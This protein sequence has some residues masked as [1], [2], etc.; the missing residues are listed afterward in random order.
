MKLQNILIGI[1][2]VCTLFFGYKTFFSEDPLYKQKIE[3]LH[4]E[5]LA[6]QAKRDSINGVLK[7]L[8]VDFEKLKVQEAALNAKVAQ[9]DKEIE[10]NKAKAAKSQAELTALQKELAD[11]HN[12]IE[13]LKKHPANRTGDD[14]LN[15]LK[16][17]SQ[18]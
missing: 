16:L 13:D 11:T 2:T 12:K 1:L 6:L 8:K 3:E 5:N 18:Q 17:K 4:K 7:T 10:K 14:L 9:E 15:S